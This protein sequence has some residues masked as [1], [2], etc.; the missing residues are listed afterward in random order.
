MKILSIK[1]KGFKR[2]EEEVNYT[3]SMVNHIEGDNFLGKTTIGEAICWGL[4]GVDLFGS[5]Q[6]F[7]KLL[8]KK[9]KEATVELI[10]EAKGNQ[11]KVIRSR[12]GSN[13]KLILNNRESKQTEIDDLLPELKVFLSAFNIHYFQR[14][15]NKDA[16]DLLMKQLPEIQP[17]EVIAK[18]TEEE[19]GLL[20]G[21]MLFN[22]DSL[23]KDFRDEIKQTELE[24]SRVDGQLD[25]LKS[26]LQ[27]EIPLARDFDNSKLEGI[28]EKIEDLQ[29]RKQSEL[30]ET[31]P[32]ENEINALGAQYN[33]LQAQKKKLES[34]RT[35]EPGSVCDTCGQVISEEHVHSVE[36][37][38]QL[39]VSEL[40]AQMEDIKLRGTE[41]RNQLTS[42]QAENKAKEQ[43]FYEEVQLQIDTLKATLREL[44]NRKQEVSNHNE[45]R[46]SMIHLQ[47]EAQSRIEEKETYRE[48]L[49]ASKERL[50]QQI[51]AV[52]QYVQTYTEMQ[53]EV[54]KP[55]LN[56]VSIKLAKLVKSSGEMKPD[57]ELLYD[58]KEQRVLSTSEEILLGLELSNMFNQ[59]TG[60]EIPVFVDYRESINDKHFV[61][62][63][64]QVF[65]AK[66]VPDVELKINQEVA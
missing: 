61:S 30:I 20:N 58:G 60:L 18:L 35:F 66:F 12:R 55:Y 3:F 62:P 2:H 46:L 59:I 26:Q 10:F 19:Q 11:H 44:E 36:Q 15:G 6:S 45:K 64:T 4:Y 34:E 65:T 16:R 29:Q 50:E 1:V 47:K 25:V 21:Y 42:I 56:R 28:E 7:D 5:N 39:K 53:N 32:I 14:L 8:N 24:I 49:E 54:V 57:F 17:E 27:A 13:T 63:A 31:R 48:E 33:L 38:R 41:L 43:A 37:S 52:K 40:I 51:L 9:S 23:Q 22:P